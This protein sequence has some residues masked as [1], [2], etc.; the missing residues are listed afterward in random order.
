VRRRLWLLGTDG[1]LRRL[2]WGLIALVV[3]GL[4]AFVAVGANRPAD[5]QLESGS[6]RRPPPGFSE[7]GFRITDPAGAEKS[8][9]A[10]LA[11]D[12]AQWQEGFMFKRSLPGYPAM[13]FRFPED[14]DG[15]FFNKNVPIALDIAW[16][17]SDGS[18]VDAATMPACEESESCPLFAPKAPYRFAVET[19]AGELAGLGSAPGSRLDLTGPCPGA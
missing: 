17:G 12:E 11:D 13:I 7:I 1:G 3:L 19:P 4:L 8:G 6:V 5:P 9:C 15:A 10:V 2:R 18:F 14:R 16:F